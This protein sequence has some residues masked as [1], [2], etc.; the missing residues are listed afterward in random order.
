LVTSFSSP[1]STSQ[2]QASR[3]KSQPILVGY[4]G[5]D[6]SSSPKTTCQVPFLLP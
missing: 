6:I 5:L 3:V 2:T 4:T 1:F